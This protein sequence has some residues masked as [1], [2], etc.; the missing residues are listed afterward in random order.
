MN[1]NQKKKNQ[2]G[3]S[4]GKASGILKKSLMFMF[5]KK[6]GFD[7]CFQCGEKIETLRELSI[8]HKIPWLDS[9]NPV[10]L[11]FNL[12]NVSFSHLSCN[13]KS[14][15]KNTLD[16]LEAYKNHNPSNKINTKL[17]YRWCYNCKQ[18]LSFNY[19]S[20]NKNKRDGLQD[21]CKKCRKEVRNEN[22]KNLK[23][24]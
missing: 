12:E 11:F 17:G 8:E 20:K 15:R 14:S 3:M 19:F 1:G 16:R 18:E 5:A 9:K 21:I 4:Y 23:N 2:L 13:V 22:Y 7:N 10:E 24:K 6:C